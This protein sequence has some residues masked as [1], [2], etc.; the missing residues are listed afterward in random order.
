[1]CFRLVGE[2]P[3][4]LTVEVLA[5]VEWGVAESWGVAERE[6]RVE[7]VMAAEAGTEDLRSGRGSR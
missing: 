1:M 3:G 2:A 5:A 6:E 7:G 4:L